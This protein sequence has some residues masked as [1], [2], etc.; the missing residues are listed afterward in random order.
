MA[1]AKQLPILAMRITNI[2]NTFVFKPTT[3][4]GTR[5]RELSYSASDSGRMSVEL[6]GTG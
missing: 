2:H 3:K 1:A 6:D 5:W 4:P